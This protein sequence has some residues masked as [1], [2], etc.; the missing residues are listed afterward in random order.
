MSRAHLGV[1]FGRGMRRELAPRWRARAVSASSRTRYPRR[2]GLGLDGAGGKDGVRA[3]LGAFIGVC[4]A[5]EQ[6]IPS[7]TG[8]DRRWHPA[9]LRTRKGKGREGAAP[10]VPPVS[11]RGTGPR[12]RSEEGR[13]VRAGLPVRLVGCGIAG[14]R[15]GASRPRGVQLAAGFFPPFLFLLFFL[16]LFFKALFK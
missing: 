7:N 3:E 4:G 5:R 1:R 12:C 6:S 14:S 15:A 13:G 8:S 9:L 16:F 11:G 2:L 10:W